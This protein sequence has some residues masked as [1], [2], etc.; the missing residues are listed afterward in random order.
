MNQS[1]DVTVTYTV[2]HTT[3]S[4]SHGSGVSAPQ[5]SGVSAPQGAVISAPQG[6]EVKR[7]SDESF[8]MT[9]GVPFD[10]DSAL[11][12]A[13]QRALSSAQAQQKVPSPAQQKAPVAQQKPP[14]QQTEAGGGGGSRPLLKKVLSGEGSDPS[15]PDTPGAKAIKV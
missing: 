8:T 14:P 3:R 10:L 11:G 1:G 12:P 6:V 7:N 13:Q 4:T 9:I 5:G 15:T 2:Q